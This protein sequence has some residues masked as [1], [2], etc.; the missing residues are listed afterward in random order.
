MVFCKLRPAALEVHLAGPVVPDL[1]FIGSSFP[2]V[3]TKN[4]FP[5]FSPIHK[6]GDLQRHPLNLT[7]LSAGDAEEGVHFGRRR[8]SIMRRSAWTW[9]SRWNLGLILPSHRAAGV[10][11]RRSRQ[12]GCHSSDCRLVLTAAWVAAT[13][14]LHR[15]A[16]IRRDP[17]ASAMKT[18][19]GK[20]KP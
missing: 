6:L 20:E 3:F 5:Q 9:R 8:R 11:L 7:A 1:H 16:D 19:V 17:P 2:R 13:S 12:R 14:F 18:S 4:R 10:P 15:G